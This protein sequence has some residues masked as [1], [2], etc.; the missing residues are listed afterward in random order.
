MQS[1]RAFDAS[2]NVTYPWLLFG[3]GT[4]ISAL[5]AIMLRQQAGGRMRAETLARDMTKDLQI[6]LGDNQTLYRVTSA[7][8]EQTDLE[9]LLQN[10]ADSVAEA[11][12][13][14]RIAII[15]FDLA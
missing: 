7:I 3:G 1:T 8:I 13:A 11:L 12:P 4:L 10:V 2:L 14:D 9:E 15:T 6:A 5:L